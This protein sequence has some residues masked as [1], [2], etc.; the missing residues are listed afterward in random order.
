M[1]YFRESSV[2]ALH[3]LISFNQNQKCVTL[4]S[5]SASSEVPKCVQATEDGDVYDE[6]ELPFAAYA[7]EVEPDEDEITLMYDGPRPTEPVATITID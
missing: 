3:L 5:F 6:E 2:I 1:K 4:V 7:D